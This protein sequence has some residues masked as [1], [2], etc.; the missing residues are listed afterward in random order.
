MSF[1]FHTQQYA[2]SISKNPGHSTLHTFVLRPYPI[3]NWISY[4]LAFSITAGWGGGGR[5][6]NGICKKK[7]SKKQ[8][9]E[10]RRNSSSSSSTSIIEWTQN[11]K[12]VFRSSRV[13]AKWMCERRI[14][15]RAILLLGKATTRQR[16]D[17]AFSVSTHKVELNRNYITILTG[18]DHYAAAV[19]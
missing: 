15:L 3:W 2:C 10:R 5:G 1:L 7:H 13:R 16:C 17:A 19:K 14:W 4:T 8:L 12:I 11:T 6:I 18:L 9:D